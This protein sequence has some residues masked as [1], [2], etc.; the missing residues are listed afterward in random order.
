MTT[1]IQ[2]GAVY[3]IDTRLYVGIYVNITSA[4]LTEQF[5]RFFF[6]NIS[7]FTYIYSNFNSNSISINYF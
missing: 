4:L 1:L 5:V 3:S 6:T 2:A 7:L